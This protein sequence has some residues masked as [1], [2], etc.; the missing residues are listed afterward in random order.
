M[1]WKIDEFPLRLKKEPKREKYFSRKT[2]AKSSLRGLGER[3]HKNN[4]HR[5]AIAVMPSE[6][7]SQDKILYGVEWSCLCTRTAAL[8]A[9][10]IGLENDRSSRSG[11][12]GSRTT[13]FILRKSY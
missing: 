2:A 13:L 8:S 3:F 9:A 6:H 5:F 12:S 10:S 1:K 4:L 7:D 11:G